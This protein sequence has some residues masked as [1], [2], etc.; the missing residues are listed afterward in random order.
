ML[1]KRRNELM[2]FTS[3]HATVNLPDGS[4]LHGL[5]DISVFDALT[6]ADAVSALDLA[7]G[8]V[9]ELFLLRGIPERQLPHALHAWTGKVPI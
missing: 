2:H 7:E 9:E 5:V 1:K 3:S 8:M 6:V 4:T